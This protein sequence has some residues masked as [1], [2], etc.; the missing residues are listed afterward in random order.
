M[1]CGCPKS[2]RWCSDVVT[3]PI[4]K[5]DAQYRFLLYAGAKPK[6]S[7]SNVVP[8]VSMGCL[9]PASISIGHS[10]RLKM[11]RTKAQ[12][13]LH[14]ERTFISPRQLCSNIWQDACAEDL[15]RA[16]SCFP[17]QKDSSVLDWESSRSKKSARA[18][19]QHMPRLDLSLSLYSLRI[20]VVD[21]A[22]S[23]NEDIKNFR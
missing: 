23:Q 15:H 9:L 4:L 20:V 14:V 10:A 18:E 5:P 3:R 21:T 19:M 16:C 22:G 8:G 11:L 7:S 6:W 13:P 1:R 2:S 17:L 12:H